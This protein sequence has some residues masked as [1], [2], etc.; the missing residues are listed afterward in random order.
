M[1]KHTITI[2]RTATGY[3]AQFSDPV[4]IELFGSDTLHTAY[5]PKAIPATVL[6]ELSHRNP[7][8]DVILAK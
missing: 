4:V 5:T 7:Q 2:R 3:T 8:Y 6:S 1:N